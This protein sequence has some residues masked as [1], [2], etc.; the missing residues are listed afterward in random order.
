MPM[1][2]LTLIGVSLALACTG[3]GCSSPVSQS[4]PE[5]VR[6]PLGVE[7]AVNDYYFPTGDAQEADDVYTGPEPKFD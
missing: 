7:R 3:V 4:S 5:S 2:R 1:Y 6:D